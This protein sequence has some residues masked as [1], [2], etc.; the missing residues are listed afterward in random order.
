MALSPDEACGVLLGDSCSQ[1]YDPFK[2]Q[3]NIL[4]PGGKPPVKPIPLP[5]VNI[6]DRLAVDFSVLVCTCIDVYPEEDCSPAVE[7]SAF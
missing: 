4:I 6:P 7:T 3:W 5:K 2:Q 1:D